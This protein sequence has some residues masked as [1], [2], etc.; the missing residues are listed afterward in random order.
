MFS[1]EVDIGMWKGLPEAY[2]GALLDGGDW[3]EGQRCKRAPEKKGG[4]L[5]VREAFR[6]GFWEFRSGAGGP[7]GS[8]SGRGLGWAGELDIALGCRRILGVEGV[9]VGKDLY[10]RH[11]REIEG[12]LTIYRALL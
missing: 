7:A 12:W 3:G 2:D 9:I 8:W 4:T 6:F 1:C 11:D 10:F 5:E